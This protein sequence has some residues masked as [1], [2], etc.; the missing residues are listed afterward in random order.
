MVIALREA[1]EGDYECLR[2]WFEDPGNNVFFTSDLRGIQEY[3]KIFLLMALKNK[4]N[5]YYVINTEESSDAV[6]FIALINIDHGD[7]FGQLWYVL[8]SGNYR[9]K[10]VMTRAVHL[11]L[12]KA[13]QELGLH[14][15]FTWVVDDNVASM[16]VLEKNGFA[17]MG[18]QREAYCHEGVFKDRILFDKLLRG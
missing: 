18:V 1:A 7:G 4:R 8:G 11:L 3:R 14:S 15:V 5:R 16:R 17:R 6:G 9:S 12:A 2:T 10:G 13:K